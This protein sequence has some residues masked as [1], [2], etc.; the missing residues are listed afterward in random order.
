MKKIKN[1]LILIIGIGFALNLH[2][3][4]LKRNLFFAEL[5]GATAFYSINY[6]RLLLNNE[7]VNL[8]VRI[9]FAWVSTMLYKSNY[10]Y[11]I[12][13][14]VIKSVSD[15]QFL[16]MRLAAANT[17]YQINDYR[18]RA[19][20][21]STFVPKKMLKYDFVPSIGIGYRYQSK[22]NGLFF[23]I[24]IQTFPEIDKGEWYRR[25]SMGIGYAF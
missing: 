5:S 11:P 14:S 18:D 1:L 13:F 20:S 17:L 24:L 21:D 12:S 16:E 9:G 10:V 2:S 22:N 6:E 8:G 19:L 3:Q 4:E 15:N 7:N 25:L 23:N